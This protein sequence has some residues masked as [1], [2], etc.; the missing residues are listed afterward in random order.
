[1]QYTGTLP[2]YGEIISGGLVISAWIAEFNL[3]ETNL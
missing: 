3:R 2:L 1:M